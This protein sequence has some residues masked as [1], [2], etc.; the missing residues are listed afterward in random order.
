MHDIAI[1]G[2]GIVGLATAV[3]LSDRFPGADAVVL[4]KETALARH[5]TG[6]NSG[7][8]HSGIYY[9]PGSLKAELATR[10]NRAMVDFCVEH[11]IPHAVCGKLIVATR[12]EQ[13]PALGVLEERGLANGIPV[14]R[15]GVD[16]VAEREPHVRALA[17]LDVPT[18]GIVDYG[19]VTEQLATIARERSVDIRLG[20]PV[21]GIERRASGWRLRTPGGG[22][23]AR[24]LV[25]CGGLHS[26]RLAAMAGTAPPAR[27]I[28][29]RGEYFN[30]VDGR[31]DLVRG[32]VYPVPDLRFPFLGVHFTRGIDGHV[33]AGPN[34][35]LALAR[36]GYRWRDVSAR[37]LAE[38]L[39]YP[40]FWRMARRHAG[41]GVGEVARSLSKARFV[42]SARELVPEIEAADLVVAPA[43][44]RAQAVDIGGNLLDDFLLVEDEAAVHVLNAPSPAAT[45]SLEIGR[46][47]AARVTLTR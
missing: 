23:E 22:L 9:R 10:A 38:I 12:A 5:Q 32:L 8:I 39:R 17:A 29:F 4:E 19:R 1:V 31:A 13:L 45:A 15:L 42:R 3:A 11:A 25:T 35:V 20:T 24:V 18:A 30:L 16:E 27:V 43:G 28:P 44:V 34:A 2:G 47:I 7:V 46:L 14:R 37:D 36:E 33:H 40:G 21:D 26:D 6:R 41:Y